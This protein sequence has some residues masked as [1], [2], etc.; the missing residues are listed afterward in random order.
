MEYPW[1]EKRE[2]ELQAE[3]NYLKRIDYKGRLVCPTKGYNPSNHHFQYIRFATETQHNMIPTVWYQTNSHLI[4]KF[5]RDGCDRQ[6]RW[7]F[8]TKGCAQFSPAIAIQI[9]KKYNASHVFD[10]FAGWGDRCIASMAI[11]IRYTG[12][13]SNP[14]LQ[15]AY[16]DMISHYTSEHQPTIHCPIRS[17]TVPIPKDVDLVFTSPPFYNKKKTLVEHYKE[18]EPSYDEFMK[19]SL[20]PLRQKTNATI[21]LHLPENMYDD[22]KVYWGD[23]NE[24]LP[25]ARKDKLYV[26]NAISL[27]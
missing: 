5:P 8:L 13:D 17:E 18:C 11:G 19:T 1:R 20:I 23:A 2:D 9:Y 7:I 25:F 10:P 12:C 3:Y 6:N 26:W 21:I 27:S 22:L 4:D 15:T 16:H 24:I 14:L